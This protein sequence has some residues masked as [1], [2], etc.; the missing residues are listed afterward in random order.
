MNQY[1]F[2]FSIGPV[3]SFIAEARRTADLYAGSHILSQLSAAAAKTI[4]PPHQLIFPHPNTLDKETGTPNKL[5]AVLQIES[6]HDVAGVIKNIADKAQKAAKDCWFGMS[7]K[8]LFE[9]GLQD[10]EFHPLWERQ[11]N[12]LLEFYWV[13]LPFE[14]GY[15]KTYKKANEALDA[16]KRLRLFGQAA[17]EDLKDSL[18]GQR[19][20][21]RTHEEDAEKFWKR[22]RQAKAENK[23][24]VKEH[25]RLD[26]IAAIK[27]FGVDSDSFPSVSTIASMDFAMALDEADK[28]SL[29]NKIAATGA[30]Y[31]VDDF[32]RDFPYDG[33]LLYTATYNEKRLT[34]SYGKAELDV[35]P[36]TEELKRLHKSVGAPSPYY[37]ILV[38]D[39]D[40]MGKHLDQCKNEEQHQEISKQLGIFADSMTHVV[41]KYMGSLVYAGGDDVFAFLPLSTALPAAAEINQRFQETVDWQTFGEQF[42]FTMSAG[43]AVVH[44]MAPLDWALAEARAT[45]KAAKNQYGRNAIVV[46]LLKRSG[47]S[48][49]MGGRWSTVPLVQQLYGYFKEEKLS[50]RMAHD[51]LTHAEVTTGVSLAHSPM[52]KL[53]LK[54]HKSKDKSK[55]FTDVE[56]DQLAD[57][58]SQWVLHHEAIVPPKDDV[59]Q[60]LTELGFWLTFARFMAQGG[61]DE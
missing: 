21:L 3:Q 49:Q 35:R 46:R 36:I 20:A 8:A 56:L 30:F 12:T 42:P 57:E 50:S 55:G 1:V 59:K 60:G 16:R 48:K 25:E 2:I 34:D 39:G 40:N 15:I 41:A 22:I 51:L 13:A 6:E 52:I 43:I 5:V 33:D 19:Q 26:T 38:M 7:S 47:D 9:L 61:Q 4:A 27:R 11:K 17:E 53:M 44:H 18:S 10:P 24:R 45:E 23:R 31:T 29:V 32:G 54:R 37:T 14:G 28:Q 58:L